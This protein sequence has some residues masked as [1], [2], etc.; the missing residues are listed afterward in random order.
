MN[1]V[2]KLT[3]FSNFT[4]SGYFLT[5]KFIS[6]TCWQKHQEW[7]RCLCLHPPQQRV[8]G[9]KAA[10]YKYLCS[11]RIC[12]FSAFCVNDIT[13]FSMATPYDV[14]TA[15]HHQR[16]LNQQMNRLIQDD[17]IEK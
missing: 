2:R 13:L 5:G 8:G 17:L 10:L 11:C 4:G 6:E 3:A 7:N 15:G 12:K 14:K 1:E 9:E 16:N